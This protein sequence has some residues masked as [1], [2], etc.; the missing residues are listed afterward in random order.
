MMMRLK[1][2]GGDYTYIYLSGKFGDQNRET[3]WTRSSSS[4]SIPFPSLP[5]QLTADLF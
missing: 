1:N 5:P 3:T 4:R 2:I